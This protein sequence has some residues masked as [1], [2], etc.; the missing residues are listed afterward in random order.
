MSTLRKKSTPRKKSKKKNNLFSAAI[1]NF[2]D[3]MKDE[4]TEVY[5]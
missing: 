5:L 4:S 3:M 2:K 1:K